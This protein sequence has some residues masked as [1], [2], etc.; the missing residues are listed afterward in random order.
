M[1]ACSIAAST[2]NVC[3]AAAERERE[4]AAAQAQ[5]EQLRGRLADAERHGWQLSAELQ[6]GSAR[7]QT[8]VSCRWGGLH[9]QCQLVCLFFYGCARAVGAWPP[10][11]HY[12]LTRQPPL[13][14]LQGANKRLWEAWREAEE[15]RAA[16]ARA[17]L[18]TEQVVLCAESTPSANGQPV[19]CNQVCVCVRPTLANS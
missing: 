9:Q 6:G 12:A 2:A 3:R 18:F 1:C 10:E 16:M 13:V 11:Q 15:A 4:V 14:S 5:V 17:R 19:A 7:Q 8:C